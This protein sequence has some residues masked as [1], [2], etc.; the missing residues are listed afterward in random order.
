MPFK[1]W[2]S[3]TAK[4]NCERRARWQLWTN[5]LRDNLPKVNSTQCTFTTFLSSFQYLQSLQQCVLNVLVFATFEDSCKDLAESFPIANSIW[6]NTPFVFVLAPTHHC[7]E[8]VSRDKG[9]W[10]G[11]SP[12]PQRMATETWRYHK[13]SPSWRQML[14]SVFKYIRLI[15]CFLNC[16][17]ELACWH[18]PSP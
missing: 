4:H 7:T 12:Q 5:S 2:L 3:L 15:N 8:G 18:G 6:K 9:W 13:D 10:R 1:Y 16:F 11:D 14:D 17:M